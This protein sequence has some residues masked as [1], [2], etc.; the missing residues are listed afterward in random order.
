MK[1]ES[2]L[3]EKNKLQELFVDQLRDILWA[4]KQLV[5][6]L[7]KMAKVAQSEQLRKAF[8]HHLGE[9]KVHVARLEEIFSV[10]GLVP[11][12]KKCEAMQGLLEEGKELMD[13][14]GGTE[15]I[16]AALILAGQK[17]E[18]YEMATYGSLHAYASCLGVK[19]AEKLL[20]QTLGEE[21][22][23]DAGLNKIALSQANIAAANAA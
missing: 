17:V 12:P 23:A 10:L 9:T 7:P 16:D 8:T 20:A 14:F 1:K 11:K 2:Q 21:K 13:D 6:A 4:E 5:K 18:H 15:G 19:A 22:K 3:T